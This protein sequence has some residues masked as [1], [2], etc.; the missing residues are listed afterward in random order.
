M[1]WTWLL[2][3]LLTC[4]MAGASVA[5]VPSTMTYQGVLASPSG[6]VV[7]DGAYWVRFRLYTTLAAGDTNS[8]IWKE[9]VQV[10]TVRGIFTAVLGNSTSLASVPFDTPYWLGL[11]VANGAELAPR[12]ALTASPYSLNSRG[13]GGGGTITGVTAGA[14]LSGGG[15]SST[16]QLDVGAGTGISVAADAVSLDTGYTDGLYVNEGQANS[17]TGAMVTDG[18]LTA[19]DLADE[20][21]ISQ[22]KL[23]AASVDIS[24]ATDMVDVVTTTITTPTAGY[25]V[26]TANAQHT[27]VTSTASITNLTSMQ[28]DETAGG[29]S[30]YNWH[31]WSGCQMC[32]QTSLYNAVSVHR[33]YYKSAGTYTFRLEARLSST[34]PAGN[35]SFFYNPVITATFF[36]SSY[37]TVTLAPAGPERAQD[38][39]AVPVGGGDPR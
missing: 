32:P 18:S 37:G 27:A 24:S 38:G 23:S 10:Q 4:A 12:I 35:R 6:A 19:A 13:G 21:G 2:G 9:S 20:P 17:V 22:D 11:S 7:P 5:E 30:E 36:P 39:L 8:A 28:I 16:V 15:T 31:V 14:G 29:S 25:I 1:K 33:T 26:V 3:V 34:L